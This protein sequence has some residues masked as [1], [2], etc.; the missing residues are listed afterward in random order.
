M[1]AKYKQ[2]KA[3]E[4]LEVHHVTDL[5]EL[6]GHVKQIPRSVKHSKFDVR[7]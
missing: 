3:L 5:F 2:A 1:T 4:Q 6:G 7:N